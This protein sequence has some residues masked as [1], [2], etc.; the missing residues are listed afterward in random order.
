MAVILIVETVTKL[1]NNH[2][3]LLTLRMK[4]SI[5]ET[6]GCLY[7]FKHSEVL[8]IFNK[9]GHDFATHKSVFT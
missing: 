9:A 5:A 7:Y 3:E 1:V 4:E 8:S 6:L 2:S